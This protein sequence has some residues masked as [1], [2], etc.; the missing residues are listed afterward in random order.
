MFKLEDVQNLDH[1]SNKIENSIPSGSIGNNDDNDDDDEM[2]DGYSKK[3]NDA[4]N[5]IMR[6]TK[7]MNNATCRSMLKLFCSTDY[8]VDVYSLF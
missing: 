8:P 1:I 5:N 4:I 6:T 3:H 2:S 7:N